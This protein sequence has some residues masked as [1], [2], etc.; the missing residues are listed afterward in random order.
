M[1][2]LD[3]RRELLV[4]DVLDLGRQQVPTSEVV[5][6]VAERRALGARG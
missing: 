6:S 5:R 2:R 1:A 3:L 4:G